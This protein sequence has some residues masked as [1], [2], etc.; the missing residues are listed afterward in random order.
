MG[1]LAGLPD[2]VGRFGVSRRIQLN[3]HSVFLFHKCERLRVC[4]R[5]ASPDLQGPVIINVGRPVE[6]VNIALFGFVAFGID[7]ESRP[8]SRETQ[9]GTQAQ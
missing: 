5:A 7:Q 9:R 3:A 6:G 8:A 2:E 1:F 4:G